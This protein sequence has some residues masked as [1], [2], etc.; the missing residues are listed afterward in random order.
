ML[1]F[2]LLHNSK[3]IH[4]IVNVMYAANLPEL[5]SLEFTLYLFILELLSLHTHR[6]GFLWLF[7][8][9]NFRFSNN[10]DINGFLEFISRFHFVLDKISSRRMI[11]LF[12][13]LMVMFFMIVI[14]IIILVMIMFMIFIFIRASSMFLII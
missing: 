10:S 2:L 11:I 7:S 9:L 6:I 13:I 4:E 1:S 5:V 3:L 12:M 14:V 8:C